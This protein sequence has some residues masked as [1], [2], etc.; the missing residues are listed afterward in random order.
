MTYW[1]ESCI[2]NKYTVYSRAFLQK[3]HVP[4]RTSYDVIQ[5]LKLNITQHK[6][7]FSDVKKNTFKTCRCIM[8]N[9]LLSTCKS[10]NHVHAKTI[11]F[12]FQ[13]TFKYK[14]AYIQRA[15]IWKRMGHVYRGKV[16]FQQFIFCFFIHVL[17][18]HFVLRY[19]CNVM[20]CF[21]NSC[22]LILL[23]R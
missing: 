8:Q 16:Y 9:K 5:K 6:A 2:L 20:E 22:G 3:V 14:Q 4:I 18:L 13:S 7:S 12:S 19:G 10:Y 11:S 1:N 15:R 17:T 23:I 21:T